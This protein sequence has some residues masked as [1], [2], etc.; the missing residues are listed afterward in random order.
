[1]AVLVLLSGCATNSVTTLLKASKQTDAIM[2]STSVVQDE[3]KARAFEVGT[4][5][6][7]LGKAAD[8]RGPDIPDS[9]YLELLDTQLTHQSL[10][11]MRLGSA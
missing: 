10:I 2:P 6:F 11:H 9:A 1:M 7:D 5:A 8:K 4:V 3:L